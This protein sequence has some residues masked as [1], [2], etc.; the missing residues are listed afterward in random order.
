MKLGMLWGINDRNQYKYLNEVEIAGANMK[1]D[2]LDRQE[3]LYQFEDIAQKPSS[4][5][6]SISDLDMNC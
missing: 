3:S 2:E 5:I 6:D 1:F 4:K